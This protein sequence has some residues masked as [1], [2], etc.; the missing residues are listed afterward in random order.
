MKKFTLIEV[1]IVISIIFILASV[2]LPSL[3]KAREK[4]MF[5]ICISHRDRIYKAMFTGIE[6]HDNYTPTIRDGNWTNPSNPKWEYDDWLG[7][8]RRDGGKLINGVIEEYFPDYKQFTRC[9]SLPNGVP[10]DGKGSNGF[11][12][13]TFSP[14]LGRLD[15][16]KIPLEL[17]WKGQQVAVP[18]VLEEDPE[19][20]NGVNTEAAFAYTDNL[21]SWHDFGRKGGYTAID[22]HSEVLYDH[23]DTFEANLLQIEYEGSIKVMNFTSSLERWPRPW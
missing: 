23:G 13:Y 11:F 21:G 12:D 22:G 15:I 19:S 1:I 6:E 14:A 20:I 3:T 18:Y 16:Y 7:A 5:S 9:P 17:T 2:L 10:G 8:S 4:A